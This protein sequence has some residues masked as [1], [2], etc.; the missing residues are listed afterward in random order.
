[1][2]LNADVNNVMIRIEW[3]RLLWDPRRIKLAQTLA[4]IIAQ[5]LA[6]APLPDN[7][8]ILKHKAIGFDD[9]DV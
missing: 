3:N 7:M 2:H 1:M 4:S 6:R 5:D 8:D 9:Y